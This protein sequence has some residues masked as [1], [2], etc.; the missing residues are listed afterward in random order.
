VEPERSA[1]HTAPPDD[2]SHY[3]QAVSELRTE[4]ERLR[5]ALGRIAVESHIDARKIAREALRDAK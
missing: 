4:N 5:S 3:M 1:A 2:L